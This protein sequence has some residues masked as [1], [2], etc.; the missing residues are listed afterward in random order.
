MGAKGIVD[1]KGVK[2]AQ[3]RFNTLLGPVV[4]SSSPTLLSSTPIPA[5]TS[6]HF[7]SSMST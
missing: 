5:M 3:N 6:N 1:L 2:D 4:R 7:P